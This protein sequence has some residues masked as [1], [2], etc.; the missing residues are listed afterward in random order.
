[1]TSNVEFYDY[2]NRVMSSWYPRIK[3]STRAPV[4]SPSWQDVVVRFKDNDELTDYIRKSDYASLTAPVIAA[5]IAFNKIPSDGSND[6][7]FS[8]RLNAS[9]DL[10]SGVPSV[11]DTSS[12]PVYIN[13]RNIDLSV[14]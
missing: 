4:R 6:W 2:F 7:D 1:M 11:V 8:I 14:R 12:A 5:A 10:S 13:Q 3:W 9:T